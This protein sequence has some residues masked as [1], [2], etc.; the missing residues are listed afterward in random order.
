MIF[1]IISCYCESYLPDSFL[2]QFV[3][4]YRSATDFFKV[5]FVSFYFAERVY[6]L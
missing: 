2:S 4:L 1:Y 6:Q 5:K 3:V